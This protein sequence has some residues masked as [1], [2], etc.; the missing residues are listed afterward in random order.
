[1]NTN[2]PLKNKEKIFLLQ[3][4]TDSTA[5]GSLQATALPTMLPAV[6]I[7]PELYAR[8]KSIL[9]QVSIPGS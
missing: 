8:P 9:R 1:M 3:A 6:H 7:N 4:R 2:N 5:G